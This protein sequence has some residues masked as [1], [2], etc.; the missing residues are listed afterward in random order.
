MGKLIDRIERALFGATA[1]ERVDMLATLAERRAMA[2]IAA[3][4]DRL[5]EEEE[6]ENG[7]DTALGHS[8]GEPLDSR[9][10]NTRLH[11]SAQER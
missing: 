8:R 11:R 9:D 2:R 3:A 6:E 4:F 7:D 5:N 10:A 1:S